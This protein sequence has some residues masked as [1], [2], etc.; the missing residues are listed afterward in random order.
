MKPSKA[1]VF[2]K[3]Q[4]SQTIFASNVSIFDEQSY[5][6]NEKILHVVAYVLLEL[7]KFSGDQSPTRSVTD[8]IECVVS[9]QKLPSQNSLSLSPQR[10]AC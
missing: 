4:Y 3:L 2:T 1:P 10:K 9:E 8:L 6:S 5:K 7:P